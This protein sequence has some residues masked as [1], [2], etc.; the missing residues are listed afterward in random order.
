LGLFTEGNNAKAFEHF[1]RA[2]KIDPGSVMV[3]QDAGAFLRSLG[4]YDQAVK[5]LKRAARLDPHD[6]ETIMQIAQC[7]AYMGRHQKR[8]K[9]D[10]KGPIHRRGRPAGFKRLCHPIG[11]DGASRR[12]R[13]GDP[14][15]RENRPHETQTFPSIRSHRR[16]QRGQGKGDGLDEWDGGGTCPGPAGDKPMAFTRRNVLLPHPGDE[17]RGPAEYRKRDRNRISERG[18]YLYPYPSL[19]RNPNFK[20]L[21]GDP[22][23]RS[24]LKKQKDFYR[25]E[26]KKFEKL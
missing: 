1:Q 4:L 8:P 17:G 20:P 5:Y 18:M 10:E 2:L 3:N 14:S 19:S 16:D 13:D 23:F 25:K 24:I 22:R 12:S 15:L 26:L 21:R 11:D 9:T 7:R 6:P